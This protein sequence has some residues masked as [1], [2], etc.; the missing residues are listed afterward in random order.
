MNKEME[1]FLQCFFEDFTLSSRLAELV[2]SL[3]MKYCV[4]KRTNDFNKG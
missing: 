4:T 3:K 2:E 1:E